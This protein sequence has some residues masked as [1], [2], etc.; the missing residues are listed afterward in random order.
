MAVDGRVLGKPAAP[1][2]AVG[3]WPPCPGRDASLYRGSPSAGGGGGDGHGATAVRFLSLTLE[4]IRTYV[5]TGKPMDK[6]RGVTV[7]RRDMAACWW[8][9]PGR[10]F[11]R[12]G[13]AGIAG[14]A[15]CATRFGV[16]P[17]ALAAEKGRRREGL[18]SQKRF[19]A[20]GHRLSAQVPLIGISTALM[21]V[22]PT[23]SPTW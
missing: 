21:G 11:Q 7:S 23:P 3:R 8:G 1:E 4:E 6:A 10:L 18:F 17:L 12:G 14:W 16:E 9:Y 15:G 22:T 2:D 5:S 19:L 13:P 20:A